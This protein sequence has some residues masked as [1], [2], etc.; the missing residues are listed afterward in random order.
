MLC[1]PLTIKP[2]QPSD[3][4]VEG[5]AIT[6]MKKSLARLLKAVLPRQRQCSIE[7]LNFDIF[8][9]I[10]THVDSYDLHSLCLAS[11]LTY[12]WAFRALYRSVHVSSCNVALL[13]RTLVEKPSYR[14]IIKHAVIDVSEPYVWAP[15]PYMYAENGRNSPTLIGTIKGSH[16]TQVGLLISRLHAVLS[17]DIQYSSCHFAMLRTF[18]CDGRSARCDSR[19]IREI[20]SYAL[21]GRSFHNLQRLS[22]QHCS[23][24]QLHSIMNLPSLRSL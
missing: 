10:L 2:E 7:K 13:L 8:E 22:I 15:V 24:S 12:S 11:W 23:L 17:F 4:Y 21:D 16:R 14:D 9:I 6:I 3:R 19:P 1:V 5:V 20:L 18:G